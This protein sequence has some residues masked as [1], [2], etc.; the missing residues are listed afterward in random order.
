MGSFVN[1]AKVIDSMIYWS[2]SF[3]SI[4]VLLCI[5]STSVA[6]IKFLNYYQFTPVY[7]F[8]LST[9]N[10]S[11][12][13]SKRL[14]MKGILRRMKSDKSLTGSSLFDLLTDGEDPQQNHR[15]CRLHHYKFED[16]VTCLNRL[17]RDRINQTH[18]LHFAFVGD[19]TIREQYD[20]FRQVFSNTR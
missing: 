19:S 20:N 13:N 6:L 2:N 18:L 7:S 11:L 17:D 5:G 8:T 15:N 1:R 9:N 10:Q 14:C 16:V 12:D 4:L 3:H